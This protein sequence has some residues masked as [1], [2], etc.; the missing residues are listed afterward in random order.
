MNMTLMEKS[1]C[2]ISGVGLGQE[3]W[4][5]AMGTT[6]YLVN[7]SPSSTLDEKNPYKVWTSKKPSLTHLGI[8]GC[9]ACVQVPKEKKSKLD[10]KDKKCIFIGYKDSL[11]GYKIWNP[12]TK[13]VVYS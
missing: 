8:F 7:Q 1:R 5:E 10:K 2:M 3:F 9:D 13:K 11:K 4:A 6:C 12:E